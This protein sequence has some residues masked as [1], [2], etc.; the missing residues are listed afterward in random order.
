MLLDQT[1]LIGAYDTTID[2]D[3]H[4][5]GPCKTGFFPNFQKTQGFFPITQAQ[6]SA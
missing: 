6:N 2:S 1:A 5:D 4:A 3:F